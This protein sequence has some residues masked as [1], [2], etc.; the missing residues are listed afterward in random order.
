VSDSSAIEIS[1]SI[2]DTQHTFMS[3]LKDFSIFVTAG[4]PKSIRSDLV[5]QWPDGHD[6]PGRGHPEQWMDVP[7][8]ET[9][10]VWSQWTSLEWHN[11]RIPQL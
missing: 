6:G 9:T 5:R 3:S 10:A 1:C 8:F 11:G 2:S 4:N 7:E